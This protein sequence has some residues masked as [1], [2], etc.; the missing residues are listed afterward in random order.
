MN[1]RQRQAA[2]FLD[3]LSKLLVKHH[4]RAGLSSFELAGF[5]AGLLANVLAKQHGPDAAQGFLN[6][7]AA[8]SGEISALDD[9]EALRAWL[10]TVKPQ[11]SA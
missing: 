9:G 6:Q 8:M 10:T 2:S 11:G 7:L 3:D 1:K 4:K 5:T